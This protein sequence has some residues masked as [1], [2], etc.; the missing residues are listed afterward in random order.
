V[1]F[2]VSPTKRPEFSR[3][4]TLSRVPKAAALKL[5]NPAAPARFEPITASPGNMVNTTVRDII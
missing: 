5:S 2:N 4:T 1:P 3:E